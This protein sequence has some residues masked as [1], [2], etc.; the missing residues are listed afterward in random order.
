MEA[1][2]VQERVRKIQELREALRH[3]AAFKTADV[4][5]KWKPCIQVRHLESESSTVHAN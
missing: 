4:P 3:E 1:D 2:R 5:Q